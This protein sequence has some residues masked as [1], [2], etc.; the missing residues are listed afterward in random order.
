MQRKPALFSSTDS[1]SMHTHLFSGTIMLPKH[2]SQFYILQQHLTQG[3][4]AEISSPLVYQNEI[5]LFSHISLANYSQQI[6]FILQCLNLTLQA[7]AFSALQADIP[8]HPSNAIYR[9]PPFSRF[10]NPI[11]M[12]HVSSSWMYK[13]FCFYT[14]DHSFFLETAFPLSFIDITYYCLFFF[15]VSSLPLFLIHQLHSVIT[16]KCQELSPCYLILIVLYL[17]VSFIHLVTSS[18]LLVS[19]LH[20]FEYQKYPG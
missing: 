19:C 12:F 13:Q 16:T 11:V 17:N 20:F 10:S 1:I 14:K 15:I 9:S 6:P 3:F 5:S 4:L 18:S 2:S 8:T 7:T